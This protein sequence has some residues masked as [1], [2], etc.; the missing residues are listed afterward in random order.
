MLRSESA[1][2]AGL[3]SDLVIFGLQSGFLGYYP[4]YSKGLPPP[5]G[6]PPPPPNNVSKARFTWTVLKAHTS[7]TAGTV[8]LRSDHPFDIPAVNFRYFEEG[9]PDAALPDLDA[10]AEGAEFARD[11]LDSAGMSPAGMM[12]DVPKTREAV[13]DYVRDNAWGHHASCTCPMGPSEPTGGDAK[14]FVLDSKFRVRGTQGL[15]VVDAS[16]FPKIP[17]LF[18]VTAIYM[19]SEKAADVILAS[20]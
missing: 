18:I 2:T 11:I 19:A 9:T 10:L 1:R 8:R 16:I 15:R 14:R 6:A 3:P 4:G 5:G 20:A 13:R 17:G 7:N 12:R